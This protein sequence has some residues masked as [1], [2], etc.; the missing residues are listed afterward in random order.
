MREIKGGI[1]APLGFL[2]AG[3]HVGIKKPPLLDLALVASV[4]EGP[5]AGV[6]TRNRVAAAPVVLDRRRLQRGTGR[7]I[8]INS[9]NANACTGAQ[10]LADAEEL[11]ALAAGHLGTDPRGMFVGST[12]VI[13]QPLPMPCIRRG[14]PTLVKRLRPGGGREAARAILTTDTRTKEV[15]LIARI[16]GR[17][18]TVGGMA[19]GSG[20]IHPDMA[21]ML[22]YLTTDAVIEQRTLQR[23]LVRAVDPSFNCISVDGDT[24]TNDS[25]LCLANGL[26]GN[27]VVR[28]GSAAAAAFQRLLGE[29]CRVLAMQVCRDG[30]GATKLVQVDV[31]GARTEAAAKLVAKT[32][33][34]STL[35]KAALFGEDANWGRIMAAIGRSGVPVDPS[36]IGLSCDGVPIVRAGVGLGR[37]AERRLARMMQRKEFAVTIDLGLGSARARLWTTDLSDDYLT[38]NAS[39]RS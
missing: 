32:V 3:M 8:L 36:R 4:R 7:A 2:A 23:A 9:G 25:V 22:A 21:T 17:P 29:A 14:I 1:T 31:V 10:G 28:A 37:P 13:G 35:V 39:Y 18:V 38:L 11:A 20:M 27:P 33:A 30:E 5:I 24:S 15:A 26:A 6:F 34:T 19:K 16:A 12:G